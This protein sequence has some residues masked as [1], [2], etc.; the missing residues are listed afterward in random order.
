[1][2]HTVLH[3]Q[4]AVKKFSADMDN[5]L[6]AFELSWEEWKAVGDLCDMLKVLK[7]ATL[8]FSHAGTPTLAT[9][10][11]AM[12]VID[13]VFATAAV[14]NTKFSAPI[15]ASLLVA[16]RTLNRYYQ[17]TDDSDVYR[18]AMVLHPVHKLDYF[19]Q[20]AWEPVWINDTK[21]IVERVFTEKYKDR[22]NTGGDEIVEVVPVRFT[23]YFFQCFTQPATSH[24]QIC[25]TTFVTLRQWRQP[26]KMS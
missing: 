9:V 22:C 7:D 2:L 8:Y 17:L 20:A 5:D 1:M 26:T 3:Y 15:R 11:P 13:K 21:A 12:D 14:N 10:I 24:L 25:S 6:R 4:V 23:V 18:I 16:K 19:K